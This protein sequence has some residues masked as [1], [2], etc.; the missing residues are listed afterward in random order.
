VHDGVVPFAQ[1]GGVAQIGRA[2]V[3]PVDEVMAVGVAPV[4][5]T[6]ESVAC[7]HGKVF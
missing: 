3:R 1:E 7:G 5:R 4:S 6:P 2:E